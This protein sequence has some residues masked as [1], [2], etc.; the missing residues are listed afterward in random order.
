MLKNELLRLV[1]VLLLQSCLRAWAAA[2]DAKTGA[3]FVR[4]RLAAEVNPGCHLIGCQTEGS[5]EEA[6]SGRLRPQ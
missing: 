3:W 2:L 4:Q 5:G 1:V 6:E